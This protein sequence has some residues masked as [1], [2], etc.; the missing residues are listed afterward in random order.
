MPT[1][2][3]IGAF[4]PLRLFEAPLPTG[5]G[6][7]R[8]QVRNSSTNWEF[9]VIMVLVPGR[10]GMEGPFASKSAGH[11]GQYPLLPQCSSDTG[12]Q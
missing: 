7:G 12:K 2:L 6:K 3:P 11:P 10:K 5:R 9:L 1:K 8:V 4:S